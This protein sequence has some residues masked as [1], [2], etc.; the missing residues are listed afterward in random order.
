VLFRESERLDLRRWIVHLVREREATPTLAEGFF[1]VALIFVIQFFTRL[2]I[3]SHVPSNPDFGY[4]AQLLFISQVVCIALPALLM[5]LMFTRSR[6]KTLLLDRA[7]QLTACIAAV[8]LA[9]LIQP[10]GQQLTAWIQR[11]YPIQDQVL[12]ETQ[13]FG[14]LLET[15]PFIWLPFVLMALLPAM[16]E[17]IAFRGFILSGLRHVGNKWWAIALSAVF[18][19]MAHTVIQQ[20]IA[21]TAL[22]LVLGYLA[23]QSGSLVPCILFHAVY[24]SL[25]LS[26][27]ILPKHWTELADRVP[28]VK[29]LFED[30]GAGALTYRT[31]VVI[32][33]ALLSLAVLAWF[34]RLPYQATKEEELSDARALQSQQLA[35]E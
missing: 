18:F 21:A 6:L 24:N 16:C 28:I 1:C 7:P 29:S 33:S 15:A 12:A 14:K 26:T 17:E 13:A 30:A 22:G 27:A 11:L 23:V 3:S 35:T 2:A 10:L 34:H 20:S 5:T 32:G 25:M 4:L 9:V 8:L 31:P 19:G